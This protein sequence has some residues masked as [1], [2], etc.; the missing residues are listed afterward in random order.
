MRMTGPMAFVRLL[1]L[2]S[3]FVERSSGPP[4]RWCYLLTKD[5]RMEL[6]PTLYIGFGVSGVI[7]KGFGVLHA[8]KHQAVGF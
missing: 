1:A 7:G 8:V 3:S 5:L 2:E 4:S 6:C